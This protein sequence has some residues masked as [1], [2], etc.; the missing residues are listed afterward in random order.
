[1]ERKRVS[2]IFM[3]DSQIEGG[4]LDLNIN[5]DMTIPV[6]YLN[7][8][9]FYDL[10]SFVQILNNYCTIGCRELF[11]EIDCE[12]TFAYITIH[13]ATGETLPEDANYDEIDDIQIS[14]IKEVF[15]KE[16]QDVYKK[17]FN[18][19]M[20]KK[21]FIKNIIEF[22]SDKID[23]YNEKFCLDDV[24]DKISKFYVEIIKRGLLDRYNF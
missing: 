17:T 24:A 14:V 2:K 10:L 12:G 7:S 20:T 18:Y 9:F 13:T 3:E 4:W 22:V 1:M 21:D 11:L 6:S 16:T 15:D 23:L 8:R 5:N 19:L